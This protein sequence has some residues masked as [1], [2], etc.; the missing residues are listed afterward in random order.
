LYAVPA[1][2]PAFRFGG[3]IVSVAKA[4]TELVRR[5][6]ELTVFTT[7]GNL[8]LDLDVP[9][10][11]PV[12]V[13]GV[14]V[15]YFK[16]QEY[17]K[18]WLPFLPYLSRASGYLYAPAMRS[19]LGQIV[20]S[21][22]VVHT[23]LPFVYPTLAAGRAAIQFQKPLFY[24]QRGVF[25]PARLRFRALKKRF[26]I[27]AIERPLMRRA[28]T[29]IALT[30]AEEASYRLL[31]VSTPCRVIPNGIDANQYR[32]NARTDV[33]RRW[34]VP[35]SGAVVLFLGRIH[36]TKGVER[37]VDGFAQVQS[38]LPSAYLVIAGPDEWRSEAKL[39]ARAQEGGWNDRLVFTGMIEGEQKLDLLARAQLF[40]LPSDAEGFSVAVLEA[41]AS[42]TA[43]LLSPGCHFPEIVTA[44]A[45]LIS[46]THPASLGSALTTMLSD[47]GTLQQMGIAAR[48]FV[49]RYYSWARLIDLLLDT[50]QEGIQRHVRASMHRSTAATVV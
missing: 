8:D 12:E 48:D 33:L 34:N 42:G 45:G 40:V 50:Y 44:G 32:E 7:N 35:T 11:R 47:P 43:L 30:Q 25:D 19:A 14:K 22:N 46:E 27:A 15:W 28:S 18:R 23:H 37:L 41:M 24:H 20:P 29:L 2:P 5:G 39:R 9:V 17:L 16:R 21:M 10:D 31:K 36:P 49:T 4:A 26:Y 13:E 3:P 38:K 6:H 1:Y